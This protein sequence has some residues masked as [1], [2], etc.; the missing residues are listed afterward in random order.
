ML[1]SYLERKIV[2]YVNEHGWWISKNIDASCKG[3]PDRRIISPSGYVIYVEI[4]TE[5]G[6]LSK[7][8]S[9][10]IQK[11]IKFHQKVWV[12][13]DFATFKLLFDTEIYRGRV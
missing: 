7:W 13:K 6:K 3:A 1:E 8:Q 4:K 5:K 11:L 9:Y 2:K 10:Y 12:I